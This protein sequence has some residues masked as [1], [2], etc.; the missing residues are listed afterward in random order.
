M[1]AGL[2]FFYPLMSQGGLILLHDYVD[3]DGANRA[4]KEF[5]NLHNEQIIVMPD[6]SGSAFIRKNKLEV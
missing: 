3:W 4:I 1:R 2:D 5:C 6:Q